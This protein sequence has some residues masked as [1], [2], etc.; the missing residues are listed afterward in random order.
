MLA[1][2]IG[3]V[4]SVGDFLP[5]TSN[6]DV[7]PAFSAG[8]LEHPG[9]NIS[10]EA[11]YRADFKAYYLIPKVE[12]ENKVPRDTDNLQVQY[13]KNNGG[14]FDYTAIPLQIY[15]KISPTNGWTPD[16][17]ELKISG[18]N[19]VIRT[20]TLGNGIGPQAT[21]W[22]G[23]TDTGE[24]PEYSFNTYT[25]EV[26]VTKGGATCSSKHRFAVYEVRQGNCVYRDLLVNEH[27]A[28]LYEYIGGNSITDLQNPNKYTVA[29]HEGTGGDTTVH[30]YGGWSTWIGGD[31]AYCPEELKGPDR[32]TK[33]KAILENSYA[34][35]Q[36]T[37]PYVSPPIWPFYEDALQWNGPTW[38]GSFMDIATLRCDGFVEAAYE[39]V[40]AQLYGG[41]TWWNIMQSG[42][43]NVVNHNQGSDSLTPRKQRM[44]ALT[45]N[46]PDDLYKP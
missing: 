36:A 45:L 2:C 18:T 39:A 10:T 29:E 31:G 19:G 43:T 32:R 28:I 8:A 44:G 14:T 21:N 25:A 42:Q 4:G 34:L 20:M 41:S 30:I 11:V 17:V 40:P 1:F 24:Y 13:F 46:I 6:T 22:N 27:A 5:M 26:F 12:I 3:L 37:I 7:G 23:K 35:V 16:K 15:Y 33:R 9:N 38:D